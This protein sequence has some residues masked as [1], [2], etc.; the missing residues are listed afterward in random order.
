MNDLHTDINRKQHASFSAGEVLAGEVGLMAGR[1]AE[2]LRTVV[3]GDNKTLASALAFLDHAFL[4][5]SKGR[6]LSDWQG[7][8]SDRRVGG[9]DDPIYRFIHGFGLSPCEMD[10][11]LLAGLAEEHEAYADIFRTL[12]PLGQPRPT[13][14][15][16]AQFFC[17]TAEDRNLFRR[18]MV[19][20]P[21]VTAGAIYT[22]N[23]APFFNRNVYLADMLWFV[24]HGIDVWPDRIDLVQNPVSGHGLDRWLQQSAVKRAL[25]ALQRRSNCTILITADDEEAAFQRAAALVK[26]A[27]LDSVRIKLPVTP[28][29]E[30]EKLIGV[31]SMARDCV[32]ILLIPYAEG[33][34]KVEVP[35]FSH[36]PG[37]II[38]S[39]RGGIG[40]LCD[41]RPLINIHSEGLSPTA[42]REM[43]RKTIPEL[44]EHA[45]TLA[46]RYPVEPAQAQQVAFDLEFRKKYNGARLKL[47][48]VAVSIRARATTG[49]DGGVQRIRP[50]ARWEH[51]V[52]PEFQLSLLKEAINRLY[53][54]GK[55]LD[56]WRF[57]EGRRG[58][59]GVRMLFFGPPGTG[60]TLSAEVLAHAL[61]VDLLLVDLSRV[62]SKWIGETEKNLARVFETAERARSVLLFDEADAL[63]GKR[64]E[65]SDAH[66]RYA[67]LETAYLLSRL[68][69]YEGLAILS[70]NLRHNIDMAFTR[71]LEFIVEFA[72]PGRGERLALWKCHLPQNAPLAD[73]VNLGELAANFAIVGGLIRNAAVAAA[74]LAAS[75]NARIAKK[76][77]INAIRREYEKNGKAYREVAEVTSKK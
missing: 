18:L 64:T 50:A 67:N 24:L 57:L 21:L 27:G 20:G 7:T 32:P 56:D 36:Y 19:T 77:F 53:L 65:V 75:E 43:W 23:D 6:P 66:D 11:L 9:V 74:F 69:R 25:A 49:L 29:P 72:E 47:D 71:R 41:L 38:Y 5:I 63:F 70:T 40:N 28:D 60:K 46:A 62:V 54:Q 16:A 14:G 4:T 48:D 61:E 76:H 45:A 8:V 39:S 1:L 34:Q 31:H 58:S 3:A 17:R 15:F 44:A 52:L 55:V 73:D 42:L 59:R 68:E 12:H 37:P 26:T 10:L 13:V 35:A 30:L 33:P 2:F 51:L 22:D